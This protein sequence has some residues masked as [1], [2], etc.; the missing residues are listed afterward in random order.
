MALILL[1]LSVSALFVYTTFLSS[2]RYAT[3]R[4]G[5][6]Y[7]TVTAVSSSEVLHAYYEIRA[8]ADLP[9]ER[10]FAF[11]GDSVRI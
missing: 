1:L 2:D 8:A 3:R 6:Q 11:G 4:T 9:I 7:S 5:E 10:R